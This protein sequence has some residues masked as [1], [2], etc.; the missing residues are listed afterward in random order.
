MKPAL[1]TVLIVVLV[2]VAIYFIYKIKAQM[3]GSGIF[4]TFDFV[5]GTGK[6]FWDGLL[7]NLAQPDPVD[8]GREIAK[9]G[10]LFSG[11][12]L[13]GEKGAAATLPAAVAV[14]GN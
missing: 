6:G 13:A 7:G 2:I 11:V 9:T 14:G 10:E 8:T 5:A 4:P 12:A 3:T 1:N